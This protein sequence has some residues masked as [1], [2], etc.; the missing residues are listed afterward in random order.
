MDPNLTWQVLA[1]KMKAALKKVEAEVKKIARS[2]EV[3]PLVER[4]K[5]RVAEIAMREEYNKG[6]SYLLSMRWSLADSRFR[7][8]LRREGDSPWK[9]RARRGLKEIEAGKL[10]AQAQRALQGKQME[11]AKDLLRQA[12]EIKEARHFGKK[13]RE[14]YRSL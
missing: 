14:L 4:A 3:T 7:K 5:A 1:V 11:L 6:F 8:L 12:M 13:A 2:R 10:V 9:D